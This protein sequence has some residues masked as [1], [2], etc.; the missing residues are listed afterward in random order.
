M[1]QNKNKTVVKSMELLN[2]FI[3]HSR[4]SLNEMVE[5]SGIP[6]TSIHR[7][8]G[9]LEGMDFLQKG[10]DGKY[11][12]GLLFLQFGQLV[13]ER[14]DIR[15]IAL[16]A[17]TKLRDQVEEAVNLIIRDGK[18]AIYIEKLD[19]NHPVRL[20]TKIGRRSPLYA[21]ACSRIILSYIEEKER[22]R[23]LQETELLP[24]GHGTIT[25]K[26]RLRQEL[27]L[28]REKGYTISYSELENDTVSIAAPIFDHTGRLVAG[29][30][31]AGPQVRFEKER[32]PDLIGHLLKASEEISRELGWRGAK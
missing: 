26:E 20:Y 21:G 7:M 15:Q 14:L 25:D 3:E 30:S 12:L 29:I 19:T 27:E 9:S 16:P 6:K 8:V 31:I 1:I 23:Y 32:I 18:E 4:L 2:L 17:M 13:A 11:S 24:I 10:E 22:E 5:L 28:A